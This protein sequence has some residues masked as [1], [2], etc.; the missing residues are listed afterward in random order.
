MEHCADKGGEVR[1][2]RMKYAISQN[3]RN[4]ELASDKMLLE[5][6]GIKV[7]RFTNKDVMKNLEGVIHNIIEAIT[8]PNLSTPVNAMLLRVASHCRSSTLRD[9]PSGSDSNERT[10]SSVP[11][12]RGGIPNFNL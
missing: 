1:W 10:P 3:T 6:Y 11:F 7:L 12:K 5:T 9:E 2:G 8:P 4:A